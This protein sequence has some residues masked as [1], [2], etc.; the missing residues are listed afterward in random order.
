MAIHW[1]GES[2]DSRDVT[3]RQLLID[4]SR[5]AKYFTEIGL[6]VG[7]RV[8]IYVPMVPEDIVSMLACARLD[9]MASATSESF[10]R[11]CTGDR[12]NAAA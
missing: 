4:V 7:G 9:L 12:S 1:V 5:A 10:G 6:A 8:A 11:R 3:Y 2:G